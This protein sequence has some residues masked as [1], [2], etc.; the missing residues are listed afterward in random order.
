MRMVAFLV[1][2]S[3]KWFNDADGYGYIASDDGGPDLFVHRAGIK[4]GWR[5]AMLAQG[6]RVEF[7]RRETRLGPKAINVVLARAAA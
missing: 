3:V 2:G 7:D 5:P 4:G 1:A 6:A